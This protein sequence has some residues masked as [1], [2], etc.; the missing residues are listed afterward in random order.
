MM[1][2]KTEHKKGPLLTVSNLFDTIEQAIIMYWTHLRI[3]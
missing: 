1:M 2:M 3:Y